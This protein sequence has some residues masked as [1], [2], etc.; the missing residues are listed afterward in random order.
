MENRTI[1]WFPGHMTKALRNIDADIKLVDVLIY[2]LDA[3]A[4]KS[5]VNPKLNEIAGNK[6]I[7]Y[8]LNKCDLVEDR[9]V[10]KYIK[11]FTSDNTMAVALNSTSSSSGKVI[12]DMIEKLLVDKIKRYKD[13]NMTKQLRA[14]VVGVPNSGKS[15]LVNNLCGKA[16]ALAGNK[17]GVTKGKQW[18]SISG[19]IDLLDTPGTLWPKLEDGDVAIN[20]ALIGSIKD[21]V[22]DLSELSF[23]LIEKL[24]KIDPK[25]IFNR[26]GVDV[27]GLTTIEI[28]DKICEVRKC[29]LKGNEPDYDRC[30]RIIIDD[31][32]KGRMGK[33][34]LE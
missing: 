5:C 22:I 3:R 18:V 33:I 25:I 7:I 28:F 4:P 26:Y 20:L 16:K 34:I 21:D 10:K 2:V 23:V 29:L 11:Y 19:S 31:F 8:V 32:R 24:C 30:S 9:D 1:N 6:P 14:M 15:T 12:V 17:P 13:K 27:D